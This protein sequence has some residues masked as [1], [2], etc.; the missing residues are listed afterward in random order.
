ME[1]AVVVDEDCGA[2]V[3]LFGEFS[4]HL[5]INLTSV[6]VIWLTETHFPGL[7]VIKT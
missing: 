4:L 6:D 7:V 3:L 1:G 5:C 2:S